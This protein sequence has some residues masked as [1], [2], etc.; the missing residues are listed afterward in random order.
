M[1]YALPG[2]KLAARLLC[3]IFVLGYGGFHSRDSV[4][5]EV[6]T[7]PQNN[8]PVEIKPE[9]VSIVV[10]GAGTFGGDVA[11]RA[12]VYRPAGTGPFPMVIFSH[13]RAADRLDRANLQHP[14][15]KGHVGYWLMKGFAIVAPVRIGYGET[16]GPDRENSG[17]VFDTFGTCTSRPDF[18]NLAKVTAQ[19]TMAA[20]SWAREQSWV[21][22]N[23]LLLEGQSVGGFATVATAALQPPG[24]VGYINFSGGA[25][26]FPD[27]APNRSCAPEQM[28]DVMAEFGITTTIPGLW[29]YAENDHFWGADAPHRWFDAFVSGGS[30]AE[31]VDAGELPGRDG[32]QLLYYGGK[33]WSVHLDR[34]VKRLGLTSVVDSTAGS[35]K[36]PY[37]DVR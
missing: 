22:R 9:I 14:I 13:G 27:R 20:V 26:G 30:T 28:K 7:S 16:G 24:V 31:F 25:A 21:D 3:V 17:A 15:P 6:S 37:T 12:E 33:R 4:A 32:H 11:M 18:R 5:Q 35:N 10:P 19:A 2:H 1:M 29:L 36:G 23:H 34:F 8:S